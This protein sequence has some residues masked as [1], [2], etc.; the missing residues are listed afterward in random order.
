MNFSIEHIKYMNN[1]LKRLGI[2]MDLENPYMPIKK[3]FISG[4]WAF[5]KKAHEQKRLYVG[6]KVMHWDSETETA[7]AKHELEYK[8]IKDKSIFL[9]FKRKNKKNEYFLIWTTTPW[10]IPFNL[11]IMVNP[12]ID[13][14][15]M[16]I[17]DENWIISKDAVLEHLNVLRLHGLVS[18]ERDRINGV[19]VNRYRKVWTEEN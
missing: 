5:F 9:K 19:K 1:D 11:A 16:K 7:L 2:W 6:T 14:V 12:D 3:E 18:M 4:Q 13:Y 15:K 10:T 8:T 17:D